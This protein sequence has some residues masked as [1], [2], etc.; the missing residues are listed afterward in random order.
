MRVTYKSGDA[1]EQL[2][3]NTCTHHCYR[4]HHRLCKAVMVDMANSTEKL[5]NNILLST[6]S[7]ITVLFEEVFDAVNIQNTLIDCDNALDPWPSIS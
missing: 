1:Y 2:L 3:S 5:F 6:L 7:L 4:A